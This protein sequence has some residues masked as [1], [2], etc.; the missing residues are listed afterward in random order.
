M[1]RT[2]LLSASGWENNARTGT[3]ELRRVKTKLLKN[4]G[5]W[6]LYGA[7]LTVM[8]YLALTLNSEC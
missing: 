6:T 7:S 5:K 8:A 1:F 3:N 4:G 2:H